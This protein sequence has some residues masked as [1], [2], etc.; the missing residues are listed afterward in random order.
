MGIESELTE[1]TLKNTFSWYFCLPRAN[2]WNGQIL[3]ASIFSE[4]L[5]LVYTKTV[6]SVERARWLAT[7]TPDILCFSPSSNLRLKMLKSLQE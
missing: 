5:V 1:Q 6:D 2:S 3:N 4:Y 7:Q